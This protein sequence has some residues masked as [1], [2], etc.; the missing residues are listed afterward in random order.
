[1]ITGL[2]SALIRVT[3]SVVEKLHGRRSFVSLT[4]SVGVE[5]PNEA[6]V[7]LQYL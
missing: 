5:L 6:A 3:A 1:M 2:R 4:I 7:T